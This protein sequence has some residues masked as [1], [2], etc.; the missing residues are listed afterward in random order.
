[1][2][3]GNE[4]IAAYKTGQ[5]PGEV[6]T[7]GICPSTAGQI[8]WRA[9]RNGIPDVIDTAP[10][11]TLR[12]PIVVG[13]TATVAGVVSENPWPARPQR[14]GA[15]VRRRHQHLRAPQ[16]G[17]QRRRWRLEPLRHLRAGASQ[18]FTFTTA[19]LQPVGR[20]AGPDPPRH[21]RRR[22]DRPRLRRAASSPGSARLP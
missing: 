11:V 7:D 1:M 15:R 2:R 3:G 19:A 9:T 20:L 17:V 12:Q 5:Y 4:G 13:S 6:A 21:Q 22:H 14:P 16:R 10:T 18:S 8:G